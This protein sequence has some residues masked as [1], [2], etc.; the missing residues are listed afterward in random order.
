[1]AV[2][3]NNR[4]EAGCA[5]AARLGKL[6]PGKT[7]I[8]ALPRGG[9]PV[10]AEICA[11]T[12]APLELILVRKI[13][14]PGQPELA[15]GAVTDGAEPHYA[16]IREVADAFGLTD[17]EVKRRGAKELAEIERR[18]A[19][20]LG[21]RPRVPLKRKTGVVVDDGVATGATM[22]A[23]L[24]AVRAAGAARI[25][26]ALPVAPDDTLA[27][28]STLADE[29]VCLATPRPFYAVGSHYD[30]FPQLAD[31]EVTEILARFPVMP[32][33]Q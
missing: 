18:R 19:L 13:G 3:Y 32:E 26:L 5:L 27:E 11:A 7:V 20:W 10:A 31:A 24:D 14:A 29:T 2:L 25:V 23:A 15:V 6:D 4:A 12:G 30:A 21:S 22:R 33:K 1:M 9:V 16:I 28:L 8:A 17:E